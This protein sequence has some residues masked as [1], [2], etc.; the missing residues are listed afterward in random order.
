MSR[1]QFHGVLHPLDCKT[2]GCIKNSRTQSHPITHPQPEVVTVSGLLIGAPLPAVLST[3]PGLP[4]DA[5]L[6]RAFPT[7]S[8]RA[9]PASNSSRRRNLTRPIERPPVSSVIATTRAEPKT[10]PHA[11][12]GA[13]FSTA[14]P[15][16][17]RPLTATRNLNDTTVLAP[18]GHHR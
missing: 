9:T 17:H 8:S 7:T 1:L 15:A 3:Q 12:G 14:A 2:L 18:G 5:S 10:S 4:Q 13:S 16:P 6:A 11:D